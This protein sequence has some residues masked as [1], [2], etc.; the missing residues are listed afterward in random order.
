MYS[1][2]ERVSYL[3][4]LFGSFPGGALQFSGGVQLVHLFKKHKLKDLLKCGNM[5]L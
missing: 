1:S 2:A 5:T 4:W 3:N